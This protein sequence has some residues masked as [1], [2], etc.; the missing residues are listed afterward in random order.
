MSVQAR[1]VHRLGANQGR[2]T[3][4]RL[5]VKGVVQGVGFRPFAY[6]LANELGLSGWVRNTPVGVQI[7]VEGASWAVSMF[8][9]RL[10]EE[11]PPNAAIDSIA[12]ASIDPE[13]Q[14]GFTIRD[15]SNDPR[16]VCSIPPDLATCDH[17]L[18][19]IFDPKDRRF[20]YPFT[21]CTAC[22]PR[23][24][25]ITGLPYDRQHTTMSGF[26]MCPACRA[27]YNDP[28]SRRFHAQPNA[29][30]ACGPQLALI[31][32][33]G[34]VVSR[35]HD[36]LAEACQ[37]I[38]DGKIVAVK[39][40]GGFH[41]MVDARNQGAIK[42]LRERK[43]RPAKPFAVMLPSL[44]ETRALCEVSEPQR[45]V[46]RSPQSPI[47][48]LQRRAGTTGLAQAIA[49]NN[50]YLGVMLAYTP[51]HHLMLRVLCVP[52]VATSGNLGGEP[53]CI[54]DH[55]AM[56][57]LG[58]LADVML[59]PDRPIARSVDDSIVQV[60]DNAPCVLR[61]SRGYAPLAIKLPMR[62]TNGPILAVGAHQKAV[63]GLAV[64]SEALLSQHI[65]DLE[66][67]EA[68]AALHNTTA[69]LQNLLRVK[70]ES[71]AADLHPD[72]HST[73]AAQKLGLPVSSVQHHAAHVY[74]AMAEHGIGPKTT[75]LG[76]AWDGTG[77]GTDATVW[78]GELLKV[79]GTQ[80]Q[81][82]GHLQ[83]FLLPGGDAASRQPWRSALGVLFEV[84]GRAAFEMDDLPPIARIPDADKP[85]L[86]KM[87]K[88][89][90]NT[91][92]TTSMGRLFDAVASLLGIHQSCTFEGE[93]AMGLQF[94]AGSIDTLVPPL[95]F[96]IDGSGPCQLDWRPTIRDIVVRIR[97]GEPA[98]SIARAFHV[99][100]ADGLT[101]WITTVAK[102]P[103]PSV[104]LTGG[105][106]Q[107][108]LLAEMSVTALRDKGM[109][110]HLH[111]RV[112]PND[113]GLALGQL[114]A[115]AL[116]SKHEQEELC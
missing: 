81:R 59:T 48:L 14:L 31:T 45:R 73:Q 61:R 9:R 76:A 95:W 64:N 58:A 104:L 10:R 106:F 99:A 97:Q 6:R 77:L 44:D 108:K 78:G 63:V 94:A 83:P 43:H 96:E 57:R 36:A 84:F 11:R 15:S 98:N 13:D 25:I 49:P 80:V 51:L 92:T 75:V 21:N 72:Y 107:N 87:L 110:P 91:P 7:E 22:G 105:G 67:A 113:G 23:W 42:T 90:I 62:P 112:P 1:S 109:K 74:A 101:E 85:R 18:R 20:G 103:Y 89:R 39:G 79:C 12:S 41:L 115:A 86:M 37:A 54:D 71:V 66:S 52:V 35:Q 88:A 27:E 26:E 34:E 17:C 4:Q 46:L 70:P 3:R 116:H 29:C 100:L 56:H 93:A 69:D 2:R 33:A 40:I 24:S 50:P 111:R 102:P 16:P 19:E 68:V 38:R 55:Q 8:R 30:P 82:V 114:Y 28:S 47:V 65:G 5:L 53:I 32:M 60:I